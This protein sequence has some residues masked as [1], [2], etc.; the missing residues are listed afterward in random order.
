MTPAAVVIVAVCTIG[1]STLVWGLA[2]ICRLLA[3]GRQE[4]AL[5]SPSMYY[6][7][8]EVAVLIAA[9]NEELVIA[10]AVVARIERGADVEEGR[11]EPL[12]SAVDVG[13]GVKR[14]L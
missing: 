6:R 2:A 11:A 7:R 10:D 14:N 4:H 12:E 1:V 3:E 13:N 8:D 5:L 9:H